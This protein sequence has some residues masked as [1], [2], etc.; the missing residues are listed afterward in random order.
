M[1]NRRD[2]V[3]NLADTLKPVWTQANEA[4][5]CIETVSRARSVGAGKAG[6]AW[7]RGERCELSRYDDNFQ[8][9]T[10]DYWNLRRVIKT[11]EPR[12]EDV[13]YDIGS[14]M[15]RMLCLVARRH[16]RKCIGV[17]L[18]QPFCDIA[19][20]NAGSLRGRK[21]QI[22]IIC[23]DAAETDLSEGTI[24]Y[25]FNPFGEESMRDTLANIHRSLAVKPRSIKIVYCNPTCESVFQSSGWLRKVHQLRL[26]GGQ[27][28]T[29]W[30]NIRS[31]E[32]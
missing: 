18:F 14:G 8:Y 5:L 21:T 7:W 1:L 4:A 9:A 29:F 25:L 10:L 32:G 6:K 20:K 3:R 19:R 26:F 24:Y 31:S 22:E 17:E 11:I 2:I 28:V 13:F 30:E 15:G 12:R 23:G 27:D 16:L